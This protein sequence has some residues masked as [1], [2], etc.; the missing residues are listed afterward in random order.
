MET[1]SKPKVDFTKLTHNGEKAQQPSVENVTS[2]HIG[3]NILM[4]WDLTP[5]DA[6]KLKV[7]DALKRFQGVQKVARMAKEQNQEVPDLVLKMLG[8][9]RRDYYN[10][11]AERTAQSKITRIG[12]YM[13]CADE[14]YFNTDDDFTDHGKVIIL[15][16]DKIEDFQESVKAKTA[17]VQ[18][19]I[20]EQTLLNEIF[21]KVFVEKLTITQLRAWFEVKMEEPEVH[22]CDCGYCHSKPSFF[23]RCKANLPFDFFEIDSNT[24]MDEID[25]TY[26]YEILKY[27]VES[28]TNNKDLSKANLIESLKKLASLIET[29]GDVTV[30]NLNK[31]DAES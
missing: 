27:Q 28:L 30:F 5:D 20:A 1:N 7:E 11:V 12:F 2:V 23:T 18:R 3:T 22:P 6:I 19:F 17:A 4:Y 25:V 31:N 9:A 21:H 15:P 29:K 24:D 26:T 10:T 14:L 16:T 13:N 8:E